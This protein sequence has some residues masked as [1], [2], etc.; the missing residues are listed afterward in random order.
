MTTEQ[1]DASSLLASG[2][3]GEAV[4]YLCLDGGDDEADQPLRRD[5]ACRGTDAGFVHL[6]CLT[7][8]AETKSKQAHGMNLDMDEFITPWIDC[9]SCH[10]KY[11]NELAID[12][13]NKFVPFV[14]RQYPDDT[15]RQVEALYVKLGALS[16]MLVRLQPR[17]K[18]E[19]GVTA[20]V[21]LSLID[22]MKNDASL[23]RRYSSFA[24]YAYNAHGRLALIE[25]TEES[26]RRA[27]THF[28]DELEVYRAIGDD[29]GIA[30]AKANI[31]IAKSKYEGGSN[32]EVL[33]ASRELYKVRVA[34]LG[35][36]HE[37][38]IRAGKK[39][40]IDLH[41]AN[42]RDEAK[43]LLV[44]LLATSKQVLGPN[45]STTMEVELALN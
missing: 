39:Y 34:E 40:A 18:R 22:R 10:Q 31:A 45:H 1:V 36:E 16:N 12:I 30:T 2:D 20:D 37:Q 5:C 23:P 32:E 29:E 17:Q 33:K 24:A 44:K 13:A 28:E 27:L 3:D 6:S 11:Q 7:E 21:L 8:Y 4:C 14:R 26:A 9:P 42:R 35:E 15:Q 43:E 41:N 19:A 25:G 38:T